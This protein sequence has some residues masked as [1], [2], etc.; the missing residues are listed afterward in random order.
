MG[1]TRNL[2]KKIRDTKGTFHAKVVIRL[3]SNWKTWSAGPS[4]DTP[5]AHRPFRAAMAQA[6]NCIW[7]K[8]AGPH[9]FFVSVLCLSSTR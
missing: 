2:F 3:Q 9:F 5:R 7:A 6:N 4:V 8:P 1:M